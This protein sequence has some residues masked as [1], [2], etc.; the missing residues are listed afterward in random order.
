MKAGSVVP[1]WPMREALCLDG[2]CGKRC[3]WI[4]DA[5]GV[6]PGWPMRS[7]LCLDGRCAWMADVPGWPMRSARLI[8]DDTLRV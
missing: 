6:V 4:T 2:R 7:A 5:G 3:A 1:G 8:W